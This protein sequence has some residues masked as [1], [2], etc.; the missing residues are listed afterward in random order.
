MPKIKVAD[1]T[2]EERE[3]QREKWR[4]E[5]QAEREE[6]RKA[7]YIPSAD[8]WVSEF[9]TE[10]PEQK[11]LLD[12]HVR[13]F[14]SKATEEL[15][16]PGQVVDN[17]GQ[18]LDCVARVLLGLKK[19]WIKEVHS[20]VGELIAWSYFGDVLGNVVESVHRY[21]LKQSPTFAKSFWELLKMRDKRYGTQKTED[22]AVIR[23]ELAGTYVPPQ[24]K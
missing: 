5:K 22:A 3:A 17:D 13:D 18:T 9:G 8:E 20:P 19:N 12:Q 7:A 23:A 2:P 21:G 24:A 15:G 16:R 10:F 11:K 4:L 1:M 14:S 6:K